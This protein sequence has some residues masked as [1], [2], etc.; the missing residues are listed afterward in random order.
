MI[1]QVCKHEWC[2]IC[3]E[4][5]PV[6]T[7]E[8]P[9]YHLYL[10]ILEFQGLSEE[11]HPSG[12]YS[13]EGRGGAAFWIFS[14]LFLLIIA[15][16]L[17]IVVN[18]LLSPCYSLLILANCCGLDKSKYKRWW[19]I[20]L[21][22]FLVIMLYVSVPVVFFMITIPQVVIFAGKKIF[23]LKDLLK[24][25]CRFYSKLG[26]SPVMNRYFDKIGLR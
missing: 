21:I 6:H 1:C 24:H 3:N 18:V 9:N 2:W 22:I 19:G 14:T 5:F 16:P 25:K 23:E 10:E 26:V 8:C 7:S 17:V 4:D 20:I 13:I 11:M 15:L 12:W